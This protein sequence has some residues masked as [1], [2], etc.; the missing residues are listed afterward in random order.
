M[1]NNHSATPADD[2]FEQILGISP[3]GLA[4]QGLAGTDGD[5]AR[6][7]AA[8]ASAAQGQAPTILQLSS[9]D[10]AGHI[11]STGS[12]SGSGARFHGGTPFPLGLSLDQAIVL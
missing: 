5:L 7:V 1:A 10:G 2:F 11:T 8:A 6:A 4:E 9:G 12:G 3:F